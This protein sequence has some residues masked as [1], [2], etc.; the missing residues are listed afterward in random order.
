MANPK[1]KSDYEL[2]GSVWHLTFHL[3][4]GHGII[5]F[6]ANFAMSVQWSSENYTVWFMAN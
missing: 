6:K 1:I 3:A 4:C 5:P 2:D